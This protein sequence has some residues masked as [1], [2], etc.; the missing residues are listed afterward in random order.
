MVAMN[1]WPT[2]AADGS[3][4][5]EARWRKMGRLWTPTGAAAAAAGSALQP[6]LAYPNLT[7]K[8]G[9]CW[10][11]GHYCELPGD[12]VLGVTA[13]GLAV[14]RFDPAANT[15]DLVYRDG[16]TTPAQSPTGTY[17]LAVAKITGSTLVDMRPVITPTGDLGFSSVAARDATITAP[18]AGMQVFTAAESTLWFYN[19]SAWSPLQSGAWTPYVPAWSADGGGVLLGNGVIAGAYR[20]LDNKTIA[21]RAQLS[22]GS[23]SAFGSGPYRLSLPPG[24]TSKAQ[25]Y[26]AGKYISATLHYPLLVDVALNATTMVFYQTQTGVIV[27]Q[28][29]PVA[30]APGYFL[31]GDA[32]FEI[33]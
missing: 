19:G 18:T 28:N 25:Q 8:A 7:V 33:A 15:A 1:V 16:I 30:M 21:V 6:T 10:V 5:N 29:S 3:V 20:M 11:D 26:G 13:N 27:S 2:D 9:A 31:S 22:P 12:Q 24:V 14:V 4:A 32:L 23:T 17:E